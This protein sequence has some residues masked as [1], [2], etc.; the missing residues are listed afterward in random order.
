MRKG[1][2]GHIMTIVVSLIV[3]MLGLVLLWI[4]FSNASESGAKFAKD[5]SC[6]I[7]KSVQSAAGIAGIVMNC[8]C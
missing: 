2:Q 8:G 3:A 4:F 5:V 6:G 1:I 7:C